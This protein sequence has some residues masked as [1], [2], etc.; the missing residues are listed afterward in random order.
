MASHV[1]SGVRIRADYIILTFANLQMFSSSMASLSASVSLWDV[2]VLLACWALIWSF[3]HLWGATRLLVQTS[4]D[5]STTLRPSLSSGNL[6]KTSRKFRL[7]CCVPPIPFI[8]SLACLYMTCVLSGTAS[9]VVSQ[10]STAN[11]L[12]FSNAI[13][14]VVGEMLGMS[15]LEPSDGFLQASSSSQSYFSFGRRA[16][17]NFIFSSERYRDLDATGTYPFFRRTMGYRG[18]KTFNLTSLPN[19]AKP[20]VVFIMMETWRHYDVGVLGGSE[21]KR[22]RNRTATPNFDRL[23]K[24]GIRFDNFYANGIQTTRTLMSTLF[25]VMPQFSQAAAMDSPTSASLNISGIPSLL[26]MIGYNRTVFASATDLNYQ[27]WN[28]FLP[29][30][31]VDELLDLDWFENRW[32]QLNLT[33]PVANDT[34]SKGHF[35][36]HYPGSDPDIAMDSNDDLVSYRYTDTLNDDADEDFAMYSDFPPQEPDPT[37]PKRNSWGLADE[38]SFRVLA[39]EISHLSLAKSP[40]FLDFYS[41]SS[42]HPFDVPPSFEVPAWVVEEAGDNDEYRKY[43]EVLSYSDQALGV[44][45]DTMRERGIM[46][47]TIFLVA[48]DHGF[49]FCEHKPCFEGANFGNAQSK[50]YDVATRVPMLIVSDLITKGS[51]GK[52]IREAASQVDFLPTVLDMVGIPKEGLPQHSIGRSLMRKLGGGAG[53]AP[54]MNTFNDQAIGLKRGNMKYVF[55]GSR[56]VSVY[57]IT[58][59][60]ESAPPIY[61]HKMQRRDD[62]LVGAPKDLMKVKDRV[63]KILSNTNNCYKTNAFIP[64]EAAKDIGLGPDILVDLPAE[65]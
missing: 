12:K 53:I 37:Q 44:F 39:D 20:N 5:R 64:P 47:N 51:Q 35:Q 56:M 4:F 63:A 60:N 33:S 24:S 36:H 30:H 1:L 34:R 19:E 55:E 25:G 27:N 32:F 16:G 14:L 6:R 61:H 52:I 65:I 10:S 15:F 43:L 11:A 38:E 18:Q 28:K 22:H 49:G 48:G 62:P 2:R 40:F 57:N 17:P 7:R 26:K 46:N 41:I 42:H 23:A 50:L 29:A 59:Y 3:K 58:K 9:M 45:F 31:G 13:F 8:F 54:L 21:R